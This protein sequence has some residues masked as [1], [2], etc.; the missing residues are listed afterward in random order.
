MFTFKYAYMNPEVQI[1]GLT[2]KRISA[3]SSVT[4]L[5]TDLESYYYSNHEGLEPDKHVSQ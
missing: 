5:H 3:V 2:D 1:G 4:Y